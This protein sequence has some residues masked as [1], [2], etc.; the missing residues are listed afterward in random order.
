MAKA[1]PKILPK[2]GFP[3]WVWAVLAVGLIGAV[4]YARRKNSG[5]STEG[6]KA[7][8]PLATGGIRFYFGGGGGGGGGGGNDTFP[9]PI[10]HDTGPPMCGPG[11][12]ARFVNGHWECGPIPTV[13]SGPLPGSTATGKGARQQP[14]PPMCPPGLTAKWMKGR[15]Y[16]VPVS[17]PNMGPS[18]P[19]P[20]GSPYEGPARDGALYA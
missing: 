5:D 13:S 17:P 16:C 14:P 20:T 3:K 11:Q 8:F 10:A 4:I 7:R 9:I 19:I 18:N 1:K 6:L 15:W 2:K 12:M